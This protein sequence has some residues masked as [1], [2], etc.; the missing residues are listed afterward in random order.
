MTWQDH[1]GVVHTVIEV[2]ERGYVVWDTVCFYAV[3]IR[4]PDKPQADQHITCLFCLINP[5]SLHDQ[6]RRKPM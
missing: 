1:L 3:R 5:W 2:A 4:V 6:S